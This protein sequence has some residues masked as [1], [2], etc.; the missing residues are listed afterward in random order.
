LAIKQPLGDEMLQGMPSLGLKGRRRGWLLLQGV[1]GALFLLFGLFSLPSQSSVLAGG[2]A[3]CHASSPMPTY[4]VEVCFVVPLAGASLTGVEMITGTAQIIAGEDIGVRRAVFYIDGEDLLTDHSE[5][6]MFELPSDHFIDG[7]HTLSLRALMPGSDELMSEP[8]T[9]TV[10]F[11]NGVTVPPINS[12][13][14]TP[15]TG[16]QPPPGEPF[17]VATTGDGAGGG[18][19]VQAVTDGVLAQN[20]DMFLYLG[21]V[22]EKGTYTE[23]FNWYG[24]SERFYGRFRDI[25]NPIIGNHEYENGEAPG[26][27]FYWDNIENYYSYDAGDW[28]FIAL[29]STSEFGQTEPGDAQYEWLVADLNANQGTQCTIAYFHHPVYSVGP[30]GDTERMNEIWDLM[31]Q[32]GV[33]IVLTGHDHSYQRWQPLDGSGN[34]DSLGVTQFVQGAGGHGVQEFVRTDSRFVIGYG[35]DSP[36]AEGVLR[37]DLNTDGAAFRYVNIDDQ[38]LDSG[39]IPCR[40]AAPDSTSP[41]IPS[42][43]MADNKNNRRITLSWEAANDNTG[44]A[45]YT[46]YR[47]GVPLNSVNGA[48]LSYVDS[49]VTFNSNYSYRVDAFDLAGNHST[50]SNSADVSTS[51]TLTLI[52]VADAYVRASNPEQNNGSETRLRT[53][54]SP[55]TVSYLRFDIPDLGGQFVNATLRIYANDPGSQGYRVSTVADNSW[56]ELMISY[57]N[58]PALGNEVGSVAPFPAMTWTEV[59][60]SSLITGEGLL[61]VATSTT[62]GTNVDYSSR[63]GANPPELILQAVGNSTLTPVADVYVNSAL[64]DSNFNNENQ[65]R[66]DASPEIASLLRF[67]VPSLMGQ[68]V[69]A[70]LRV[71]AESAGDAGYTVHSVADNSWDEGSTTYNKAPPIGDPIGSVGPFVANSWTEVD[72]TSAVTGEGLLS[73]ALTSTSNTNTRYSSREGAN[74][75]QLVIEPNVSACG[76]LIQEAED[77]TLTGNFMIGLDGAASDGRYIHLPNGS[78]NQWNGPDPAYKADYC[79]NVPTTGSYRIKGWIYAAS[80][81]DNSFYVQVDDSPSNGYLWDFPKNTTYLLDY[82]SNRNGADPVEVTLSAG[83][84]TVS[85]FLREDGARLDKLELELVDPGSGNQTCD[86]TLQREAEEGELTGAF[87]IGDDSQTPASGGQYVHVPNGAGNSFNMPDPANQVEYCFDINSAGSYRIKAGVYAATGSDNSFFVKV[88][89]AP[90]S[91]YLWD[92]PKNTTYQEDHVS[93]RNGADPVEVVLSAGEHTVTIFLREDGARLDTLELELVSSSTAQTLDDE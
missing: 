52:S 61:S 43:L 49:D 16:T 38:L 15:Y 3:N 92:F 75:P 29:N 48:T 84:H 9:V 90:T 89:N 73:V 57:N 85:I 64:P 45:G 55:D 80:G 28:H 63:E 27:F 93:D 21:D 78:G 69:T 81:S 68:D 36:R 60:V 62:S 51:D 10:S 72:V 59:D 19:K 40:E 12:N 33:D 18:D 25:T 2:G 77:G 65:L 11:N 71:Y 66:T 23:F 58:R 39:V 82:V 31:A 46:I 13:S 88:D 37:F 42:T 44:V 22:Y 35:G 70:T 7:Q 67:D 76:G 74:P 24:T 79:F 5:P 20:P 87:V 91:G 1:L 53:D 6:Y 14:F 26:Y 56:D 32:N 47:N 41:T 50:Q 17:V 83:E 34:P 86:A 54:G 4:T 8:V 30:Q